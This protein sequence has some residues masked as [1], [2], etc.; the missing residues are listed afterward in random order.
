M[1]DLERELRATLDEDAR[2]AP[3]VTRTPSGLT[4]RVRRRQMSTLFVAGVA[5]LSFVFVSFAGLRAVNRSS[6]PATRPTPSGVSA[7]HHNGDIVFAAGVASGLVAIDLATGQEHDFGQARPCSPSCPTVQHPVWSPDGTRLA[8][9]LD[10]G[11]NGFFYPELGVWVLDPATGRSDQLARFPTSCPVPSRQ[12]SIPASPGSSGYI[13]WSADGSRIAFE[14]CGIYVMNA[15][16]SHKTEV[17]SFG[18]EPTLSPDGD[19]IAFVGRFGGRD[20]LYEVNT[21]GSD[22]TRLLSSRSQLSHPA[23]SPDGSKIA[24]DLEYPLQLWVIGA[25]GSHPA[26]LFDDRPCCITVGWGGPVWSPDGTKLAVDFPIDPPRR[27]Y[28]LIV[29]NADG[30]DRQKIPSNTVSVDRP[31]WRPVP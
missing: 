26:K 4:R 19:R 17:T 31:A 7:F 2:K 8:Y 15:D 14:Q 12:S 9:V 16:G 3:L 10:A 20:T 24:Y 22:L 27:G 30:S 13:S 18:V 28:G 23:W 25:D 1:N 29:M 21:D 11:N 6:T 5:V